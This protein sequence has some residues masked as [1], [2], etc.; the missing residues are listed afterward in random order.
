MEN[1]NTTEDSLANSQVPSIEDDDQTSNQGSSCQQ[2]VM[3]DESA[4]L[5]SNEINAVVSQGSADFDVENYD[6]TG[7]SLA[8]SQVPSIGDDDETANKGSSCQ[9]E[10]MKQESAAVPSNKINAG[11]PDQ[12]SNSFYLRNISMAVKN[13]V[14]S[15]VLNL[16]NTTSSQLDTSSHLNQPELT[17]SESVEAGPGPVNEDSSSYTKV[18]MLSLKGMDSSESTE[19]SSGASKEC[20]SPVWEINEVGYPP[21]LT[22]QSSVNHSRSA[23]SISGGSIHIDFETTCDTEATGEPS[24]PSS[25]GSMKTDLDTA[26]KSSFSYNAGA[27]LKKESYVFGIP[28]ISLD[29]DANQ[30]ITKSSR[31]VDFLI[32]ESPSL[33]GAK[34]QGPTWDS[35]DEWSK[36]N[37]KSRKHGHPLGNNDYSETVE[38]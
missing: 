35:L 9:Q 20:A 31:I 5:P 14:R 15:F 38:L 13:R 17:T 22:A 34:E 36:K 4:A 8:N 10:V 26:D 2:E 33:N 21:S 30:V 29:V 32:G 18:L 3:K 16:V 1:Y 37:F 27:S 25:G 6:T 28:A 11:V 24:A 19:M 12:D 7:D 23:P